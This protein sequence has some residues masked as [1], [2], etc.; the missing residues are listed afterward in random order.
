MKRGLATVA[1]W[2]GS[3]VA[4]TVASTIATAGITG[5]P[6]TGLVRLGGL[7]DTFVKASVAAWVFTLVLAV[8]ILGICC[9]LTRLPRRRR[10]GKLH[11]IPGAHN[12]GW[13]KRSPAQI[14]VQICG[15][16]TYDAPEGLVLVIVKA[17]LAGTEPVT[18]LIVQPQGSSGGAGE[19][20]SANVYLRSPIPTRTVIHMELKP[21]LGEPGRP[22]RRKLVLIDG[23]NRSF[24][25]GP[26]DLPYIGPKP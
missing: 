10:K 25:A 11:F 20:S 7:Y 14:S 13:S 19:L 6:L 5:R 17:F 12:C 24:Q 23:F 15:T 22:I 3:I 26:I 2:V 16:F 18:D 9:F 1:K 4:S 21:A 8:A